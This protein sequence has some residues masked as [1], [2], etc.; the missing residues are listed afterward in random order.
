M[1]AVIKTTSSISNTL[2]YNENKLKLKVAELIHSSGFAKDT[3]N[4]TFSD[5]IKHLQKLAQ[6]NDRT[7]LNSVHISLNFDPSEK[8]PVEKLR[9]IADTYMERIG[10]GNQPYLVYQHHDS[11]HPHLHI[12]TTNIQRDGRRIKMQNIGRNQSEKARR[13]I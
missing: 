5:K 13:E 7:R 10:F 4:L 12:V 2:H 8:I 6:L 1:V 3:E 11:G 9:E